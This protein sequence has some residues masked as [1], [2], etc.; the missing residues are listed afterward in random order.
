MN[1]LIIGTCMTVVI[2]VRSISD[3]KVEY[4]EVIKL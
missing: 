3:E 2:N 1:L 4:L